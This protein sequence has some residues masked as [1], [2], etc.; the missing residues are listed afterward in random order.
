MAKEAVILAGG[1][2]TRLKSMVS[3]VPKSMAPIK[4]LPFL[5][6]LLEQLHNYKFEK[7]ILAAGYKYEVIESYF[8][9][10]YKNIELIY[11]VEKEPL[12]T[13]GAISEAAGL[14]I[15]DYF[16]A[17]NGD[18]F[19]KVDFDR[20]EEMFLKNKSGLM[21]ALKPMINFDRYGAVVTSGDRII[22]FNEKKFCEKGFINGGIY[23]LMKDWLNER[24]AGKVFSFEKDILEKLVDVDHIGSYIS[25]GYFIDIGI[26]EDYEKAFRELPGIV[27]P[28]TPPAEAGQALKGG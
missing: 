12:G 21:V 20:M 13:G 2:G 9:S 4:N 8:G 28:P 10:S 19:F 1:F 18:T 5:S 23:M 6:Y 17:L 22:S 25:D 11:S 15:P 24:V 26:P 27:Y 14:I 7:V 3:D 16:F